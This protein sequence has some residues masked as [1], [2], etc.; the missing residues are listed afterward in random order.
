MTKIFLIAS[1]ACLFFSLV[2]AAAI[3]ANAQKIP[4]KPKT[5]VQKQTIILKD[6]E[7]RP[8]SFRLK[9]GVPAQLTIIRKSAD[10]CGEEIVFPAYGIRR[11]LPLNRAV[12]VRF[13]PK[14]KGAFGFMCGMD[15]MY[16]KIIVQ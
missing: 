6:G 16:G 10:E 1:T 7:Y 8:A 11:W 2:L 5:A 13:T 4:R 14:K 12:T 15:M 9:R 3:P